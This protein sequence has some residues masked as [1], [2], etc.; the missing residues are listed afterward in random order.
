MKTEQTEEKG[1]KSEAE[2]LEDPIWECSPLNYQ[3]FKLMLRLMVF[4]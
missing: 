2:E 1:K 3:G 4:A